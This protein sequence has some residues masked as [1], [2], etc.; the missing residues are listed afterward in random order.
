MNVL[1]VSPETPVTFWS[2]KHAVRFLSRKAA[3]PP[4]GLLTVAAMLPR[5]WN[6]RVVDA[7][8]TPLREADI[9][10]ADYV[11]I[12]AMIVHKSSVD[13]IVRRCRRQGRTVIGGGPLFT[14]G[15]ADY[16]GRVHVVLGEAEGVI[17]T[18]VRDMEAGQ[19][20]PSYHSPARFPPLT[21]TPIP[22]WDLVDVRHY[23]TLAVQSSRG[24]PYDC[25][26]CDIIVMNGR[27]PRYKSPLQLIAEMEAVVAT[28][29]RGRVFVVDDN[30]IGDKRVVKQCLRALAT[31]RRKRR[32]PIE[33][34]TEASVN[35]ADDPELLDLM[36]AAGFRSVFVGLET[37]VAASLE[38]CRKVQNTR[39]DLNV[40]VQRIQHSGMEVLGGFIIGFDHDPPDVCERQFRFIQQAGIPTAMVGLLTALPMT[41]LYRR[42]QGEGRIQAASTGNNTEA[43]LNFAPK[44]DR[45]FLT[46]G[47]ARLMQALYEPRT[48]YRR[49]LTFL[50]RYQQRAPGLRPTW[51]EVRAFVRTL[52]VLG[53]LQPGRLAFWSFLVQTAVRHPRSFPRAVALAICGFHYRM[54]ARTL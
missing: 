45:Q 11:M 25:E 4:L 6:L 32:P 19:L 38:E 16:A 53:V 37:P 1:L 34:L 7:E 23:A 2:F 9:L 5:A 50:A 14:T 17:K 22:R 52:W 43:V 10:W 39:G 31:W 51:A 30:F 35:L 27:K 18:V 46:A 13:E 44:L 26:F 15:A 24:C 48:Y 20:Q 29:W 3:F 33:F 28:G 36:V 41:R 40:A 12:S 21:T 42:L 49:V 8:T 47:Y 54:V